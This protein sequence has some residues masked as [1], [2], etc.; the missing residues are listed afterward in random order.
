MV[1]L[2][3]Y[4]KLPEGIDYRTTHARLKALFLC[5]EWSFGGTRAPGEKQNARCG[6]ALLLCHVHLWR[7]DL[8]I[9]QDVHPMAFCPGD[10]V[11]PQT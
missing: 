11:S 4:V 8:K 2:N 7:N 10:G 3:S 6:P 5:F 1:I 9:S